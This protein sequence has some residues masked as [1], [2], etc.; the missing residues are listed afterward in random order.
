MA[1]A[2][3]QIRAAA[4]ARYRAVPQAEKPQLRLC[5]DCQKPIYDAKVCP[6]TGRFHIVDEKNTLR[7]GTAIMGDRKVVEGKELMAA[8]EANRIR[9]QAARTKKVQLDRD[10]A[11]I[12]QSFS[13]SRNW[14]LMRCGILYG[15]VKEVEVEVPDAKTGEPV[16]KIERSVAVHS[17]YEPTQHGDK[18]GHTLERRPDAAEE[19]ADAIATLFGLV[20]VGLIVTHP[21]RDKAQLPLTSSELIAAAKEQSR[22]GD[23]CVLIT[24]GPAIDQ[25]NQITADAWQATEQA[26]RLYRAGLIGVCD[27][28]AAYVQSTEPL[29]VVLS[30]EEKMNPSSGK[31]EPPKSMEPSHFVDTKWMTGY[32]AIEAFATPLFGNRFA[33]FDRP[34]ELPLS[35]QNVKAFLQSPA[36]AALPFGDR[37]RDFHLLLFLAASGVFD[38]KSDLAPLIEIIRVRTASDSSSSSGDTASSATAVAGGAERLCGFENLLNSFIAAA[39][40]R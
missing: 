12:F 39:G 26:V 7:I 17:I 24:V 16:K 35:L 31:R 13:L 22:F 27:Q 5:D 38:V 18:K 20:R 15:T 23:H 37:V 29:E 10:S 1:D 19:K 9:W 4:A 21:A 3:A 8:F 36:R 11:E 32:I 6:A 34:G 25:G 28:S 33:R 30:N 2:L 40:G 14:A